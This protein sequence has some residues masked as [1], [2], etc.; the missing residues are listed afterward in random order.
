MAEKS[1]N[2][3]SREARLSFVK[4]NEAA[5]RENL[6]YAIAL[7]NQ[8]LEKEPG[9]LNAARHCARPNSRNAA[10]AAGFSKKC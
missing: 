3:I 4:A 8:V 6:D 10:A 7:F 9:F 2:E 5:Q 1:I